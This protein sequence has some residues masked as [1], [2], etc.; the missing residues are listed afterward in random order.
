MKI[1]FLYLLSL[2]FSATTVVAQ[3]VNQLVEKVKAK[4]N[5]VNDYEAT[6][7]MKTNVVFLKVPVANVKVYY[8][9]PDKLKIK[10]EKGISF[11]PKGAVSINMNNVLTAKAFTAIDGGT[12][13]IGNSSLRIVK[14]LPDDENSNIVLSTLYIDEANHVIRKAKATTKENG[15]FELEMSYGNY[16]ALGLPDKVI[17]TFNT[18]DYK[19]PKGVTF[20]FDDGENQKAKD[21]M[22]NRKGKIEIDYK[23]YVINKGRGAVG[24]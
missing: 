8:S 10:N 12:T 16:I 4:L 5:Q 24:N 17:F 22:K 13:K 7:R 2:V 11:I 1:Y 23:S 15:S 20:D 9:K 6:G 14:L 19:M 3:D 18:K 21:K